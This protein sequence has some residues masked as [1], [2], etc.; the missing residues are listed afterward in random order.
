MA[1]VSV[2]EELEALVDVLEY[3]HVGLN[4]EGRYVIT[5][6]VSIFKDA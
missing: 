5:E 6:C 4:I 1:D 2:V 3:P